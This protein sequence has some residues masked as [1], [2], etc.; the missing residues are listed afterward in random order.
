MKKTQ[1]T[2]TQ[3]ISA[4]LLPSEK[5]GDFCFPAIAAFAATGISLQRF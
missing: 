3:E 5:T 4:F 1:M 2:P